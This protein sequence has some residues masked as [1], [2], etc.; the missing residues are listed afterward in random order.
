MLSGNQ[1]VPVKELDC[2][3][4]SRWNGVAC[5][6]TSPCE[7]GQIWKGNRCE[8]DEAASRGDLWHCSVTHAAPRWWYCFANRAECERGMS[9]EAHSA[10]APFL[11]VYCMVNRATGKQQRCVPSLAQCEYYYIA[12]KERCELRR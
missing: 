10:C 6:I 2:P 4:N 9:S 11:H 3:G 12:S 1:C 8:A 7:P 5:V